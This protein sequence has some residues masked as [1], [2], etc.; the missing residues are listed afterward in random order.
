MT[1]NNPNQELNL[2]NNDTV[3]GTTPARANVSSPNYIPQLSNTQGDRIAVYRPDL[4]PLPNHSTV[5]F[6][7]VGT[8]WRFYTVAPPHKRVWK[9]PFRNYVAYAVNCDP[10]LQITFVSWIRLQDHE[11]PVDITFLV[12]YEV[13]N[14]QKIAEIIISGSDPLIRLQ[15]RIEQEAGAVVSLASWREMRDNF[16]MIESRVV[17]NQGVAA[18]AIRNFA[19][20]IGLQIKNISMRLTSIER[21]AERIQV[22]ESGK[23]KHA[24]L[25]VEHSLAASGGDFKRE[26][27]DLDEEY[28]RRLKWLNNYVDILNNEITK[29]ISDPGELRRIITTAN[30]T[31]QRLNG[32]MSQQSG[33]NQTV[34]EG[35]LSEP[36]LALPSGGIEQMLYEVINQITRL[37]CSQIEKHRLLSAILYLYAECLIG[38]KADGEKLNFYQDQTDYV[39]KKLSCLKD[40]E[41]KRLGDLCTLNRIRDSLI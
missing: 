10:N 7:K 15:N 37:S 22:Y 8:G 38:E 3:V 34:I 24:A 5:V 6:R 19:F 29:N 26:Q 25:T 13:S 27:G 17:G 14:P 20:S 4:S 21:N 1:M 32:A 35:R 9:N 31:Y 41:V 33:S 2:S 18:T 12:D 30:E 11:Q 28:K 40:N 36:V 16:A 39:L 23:T